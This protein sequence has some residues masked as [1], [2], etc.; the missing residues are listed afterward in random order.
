MMAFPRLA[1]LNRTSREVQKNARGWKHL[2]VSFE[3]HLKAEQLGWQNGNPSRAAELIDALIPQ[4]RAHPPEMPNLKNSS[5]M[6]SYDARLRLKSRKV[7][8]DGE[9]RLDPG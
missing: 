8:W 7:C 1:D 9:W 4:Y 5:L 3:G 6:R 2:P